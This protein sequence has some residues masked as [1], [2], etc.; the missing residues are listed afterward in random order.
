MSESSRFRNRFVIV[1]IVCLIAAVIAGR[2][3]F[4]SEPLPDE[5]LAEAR[6]AMERSDFQ[7]A[8]ELANRVL[9][10][11]GKSVDAELILAEASFQLGHCRTSQQ[12]F[13]RVIVA[14]PENTT[15]RLGLVRLLKMQG[16]Y[17]EIQPHA[18]A[19]L[20]A[21]DSGNEFLIPLAAPDAITLS[22]REFQ[23][24]EFCR[25]AVPDDPLPLLG[26]A[27]HLVHNGELDRAESMLREVI[28]SDPD[29]A[30]AQV[31]LGDILMQLGKTD[32][33]VAWHAELPNSAN[34][35]PGVWFLLGNWT[36]DW[37]ELWQVDETLACFWEAIQR[38][39]N[40]RQAHYRLYH[41]PFA[42]HDHDEEVL[43]PLDER[44]QRLEEVARLATRG[45]DSSS[46]RM[47]GKTRQR[48]AELMLEL[49]RLWEA[50]AWHRAALQVDPDLTASREQLA[51]LKQRL[52]KST[53]LTV[54]ELNPVSKLDYSG[55][56]PNAFPNSKA[57]AKYVRDRSDIKRTPATESGANVSFRDDA[58]AV[59]LNFQFVNG[60]DPKSGIAR[61]FEFSGG[62]V[63]V[64]D[65]D[66]DAWPDLYLTQGCEWPFPAGGHRDRLF[67]NVDG[68]RFEDVTE[69]AG[70]GDQRYSQG[71]TVGDFDNDGFPDL[72]LGNIGGNRFYHNNGDGTFSE[73]AEA[74]GMAGNEWTSSCLLADLNADSLPDVYCVNYLGGDDV[75]TRKCERNGLP[76]QCP[77][78]FFPSE[79]DRLYINLGDGRFQ[80]VTETSGIAVPEGKGLGIVAGN[81]GYGVR[82]FIANDDKPNFWFRW[83]PGNQ[84]KLEETAVPDGLAF[85]DDGTAQSCMGVAA[86][87]IDNDGRL[88]LL[89]TNF[90]GEH[91]NLFAK[92]PGLYD[93]IARSAG[94]HATTLQQM[95]WGTQFIDADLDGLLDVIIANGHLD[96]NTAAPKPHQMLAQFFHN[97]GNSR[98]TPGA[99]KSLGAYFQRP[100]VGR[101]VAR[102][103]WNRDGADDA[104]ITHVDRPTTLL[105]NS[106]KKL[107]HYLTVHLR[108]VDS[109]RD[110]IG[111]VV[112]VFSGEQM[113]YRHL[114]AGDGY[115]ASNERKLTFGLG[116]VD[117]IDR[118]EIKWPTRI[119][120]LS[121]PPVNSEVI[122]IEGQ[123]WRILPLVN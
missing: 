96:Q 68:L 12:A 84:L 55:S 108:G 35:H 95:G 94:L 22:E 7:S 116:A 47:S 28:A 43:H 69:Q 93:D 104:C 51:I 59:G 86:G 107:G 87:D 76:I 66:G 21:G 118:I 15:A 30:E 85:G 56:R 24:A 46:G 5:L 105:T 106:T 73:Q 79:Q 53:P 103:D 33:F 74:L 14:E 50:A 75:F 1:T 60:A 91:N 70:L 9:K 71:S 34:S 8:Q 44:F 48:I 16:R 36:I 6:V 98:F 17:W 42:S 90:T 123:A 54:S 49:G 101:A 63:A 81:F 62:G 100:C 111:A 80:D 77:L 3:W 109:S 26:I 31:L 39:P 112:R 120:K 19:L 58:A 37:S 64:L 67:R 4:E 40:H 83:L 41:L 57:L 117:H 119:Q 97:V 20:K 13:E 99:P 23:Y 25:S 115:Q 27:R 32:A 72:Y 102:V 110:A 114:M 18:L 92:E 82:I 88:E 52:E 61:M 2:S 38:D 122:V 29:I 113:W 65:Y 89:V 121:G 11:D 78:H 45:N 10:V